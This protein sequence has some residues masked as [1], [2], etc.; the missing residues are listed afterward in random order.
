[1][2][3]QEIVVE[4]PKHDTDVKIAV[5]LDRSWQNRGTPSRASFFLFLSYQATRCSKLL[6]AS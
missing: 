5:A 3:F 6:L 4:L 2:Q 1:M